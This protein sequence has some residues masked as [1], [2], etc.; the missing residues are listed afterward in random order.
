MWW[1]RQNMF[2]ALTENARMIRLPMNRV[3]G[4]TK[5]NKAFITLE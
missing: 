3:N 2:A 1:I 4:I 5:I